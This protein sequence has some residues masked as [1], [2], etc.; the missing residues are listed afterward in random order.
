MKIKRENHSE[1][2]LSRLDRV[3]VHSSVAAQYCKEAAEEIRNMRRKLE[4]IAAEE[5]EACAQVC[6]YLRD[7]A[8]LTDGGREIA[9]VLAE[10]IRNRSDDSNEVPGSIGNIA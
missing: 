5:R 7:N 1:D 9:S 8:M 2:L 6:E 4:L 3:G 10:A